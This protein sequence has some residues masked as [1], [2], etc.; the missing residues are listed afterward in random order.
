MMI[1]RRSGS[2]TIPQQRTLPESRRILPQTTLS[3][4]SC[5]LLT[6]VLLLELCS[7]RDI[8]KRCISEH[9]LLA[10]REFRHTQLRRQSSEILP[11]TFQ[12]HSWNISE[13]SSVSIAVFKNYST[14]GSHTLGSLMHSQ[15]ITG[16]QL[17]QSSTPNLC[18]FKFANA[19]INIAVH[20]HILL[21]SETLVSQNV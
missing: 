19:A 11:I 4:R 1:W 7:G 5:H 16:F 2:T 9:S 18:R 14:V 21:A 17:S 15:Q 6:R 13:Q 8:H 3:A 20:I 12:Q 10:F